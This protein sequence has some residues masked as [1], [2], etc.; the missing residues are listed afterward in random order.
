MLGQATESLVLL[1]EPGTA[2]KR[3]NH[4]LGVQHEEERRC[5]SPAHRR[6]P[7]FGQ[8]Q[9][10]AEHHAPVQRRQLR[11]PDCRAVSHAHAIVEQA[12]LQDAS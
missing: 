11:L 6:V 9:E 8:E 3:T 2:E 4:A 7:G 12:A 1:C 5:S 10:H